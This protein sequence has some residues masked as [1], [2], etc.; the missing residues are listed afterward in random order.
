[1]SETIVESR[2]GRLLSAVVAGVLAMVGLALSIYLGVKTSGGGAGVA[3]CGVGSGCEAVLSSGWSRWLGVSVAW[4][5]VG[6]YA[7]ATAGA[8]AMLLGG[9]AA[10]RIGGVVLLAAGLTAGGAGLYFL[11]VQAW[12][13]GGFCGWCTATHLCG[14]MLAAVAVWSARGAGAERRAMGRGAGRN[15]MRGLFGLNGAVGI[16]AVAIGLLLVGQAINESPDLRTE[17]LLG[18]ALPINALASPRI[19]R[20]DAEHRVLYLFDYTCPYCRQMSH[21]QR[22]LMRR[23]PGRLTVF[24]AVVPLDRDCNEHISRTS[25][26]HEDA[27]E[28]AK[29]SLAVWRADA[30][31]FDAYDAWL[32][33]D[34]RPP[35][36]A[37]ARAEAARRVGERPLRAAEADPWVTEMLRQN[38]QLYAD[39]SLDPETGKFD[40]KRAVLPKMIGRQNITSGA[41][42]NMRDME[43]WLEEDS[44]LPQMNTDKRG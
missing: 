20:L 40:N 13:I 8:L 6:V 37:A 4:P 7:A 30:G 2:E 5:A 1:M 24:K 27:C 12:A 17:R 42:R 29:L 14:V 22:E 10:R 25:K 33:R 35:S 18:G 19:G 38:V 34:E 41:V 21:V 39:L 31:A 36:V 26:V 43:R 16:A 15:V 11:A 23:E 3:G 9:A 28:L 32:M 44:I